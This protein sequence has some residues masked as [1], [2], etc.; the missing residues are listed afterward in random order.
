M[1][2]AKGVESAVALVNGQTVPAV[3]PTRFLVVTK[4]NLADPQVQSLLSL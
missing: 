4:D 3:V 2:A 1:S